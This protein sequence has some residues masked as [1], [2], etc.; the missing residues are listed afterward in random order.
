MVLEVG[1]SQVMVEETHQVGETNTRGGLSLV[2]KEKGLTAEHVEEGE[3][4]PPRC[5]E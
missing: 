5:A 3:G 4:Q 1:L 2:N